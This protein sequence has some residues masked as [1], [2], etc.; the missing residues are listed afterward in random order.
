MRLCDLDAGRVVAHA[1]SGGDGGFEIDADLPPRPL[2]VARC[3][4]QAIGLAGGEPTPGLPLDLDVATGGPLWD[5]RVEIE[6][7]DEVPPGLRL[8]LDPIEVHHAPPVWLAATRAPVDGVTTG[9]FTARPLTQTPTVVALQSGVWRLAA[10]RIVAMA[11]NAPGMEPEPSWIT[12]QA[13]VDGA[14]VEVVDRAVTVDVDRPRHVV[15]RVTAV[16]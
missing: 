1:V 5:V 9:G 15:L 14:E 3:V 12:D 6:G 4:D 10:Q 11:A 13:W 2:V 16:S 8:V 7:A